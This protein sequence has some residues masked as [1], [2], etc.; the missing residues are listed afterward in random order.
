MLTK[1]QKNILDYIQGCHQ[2]NGY[3]PSH[4][5]IR[6]H[7]KLS[8]VSTV[9]HYIKILQ[10]K[11]YIKR[12][13][14][15]A[16]GVEIGEKDAVINIPFKG[17]IAAGQPIEAIEEYETITVPKNLVSTSGQ[18]FALG[19]KGDSM[20]DEGIFDGDTV[21]IRKQSNVENGETAI[22]LINGN[23]V[24]LKKIFKEKNRIRLQPANPNL[25]PLYVKSVVI[26]GKVISAFRNIEEQ[27]KRNSDGTKFQRP[28]F[29][30]DGIS[31]FRDDILK[32]ASIPNASI[33]LIVTSPPYNV[34]IHYNSHADNL[35]YE[36]YLEFTKKWI[37][38]CFDLAKSE[39]RFLLNI[40][41]DKNKGGQKSVGADITRIAK[42][43]GW[44][45]HS[46]IIW[47][48]GNISR[49]TAWGSFMSAS[50]PYV[51]AP[52]ELILVLYKDSWKKTGG[53]RKND[54]TKQEFMDWTN[55]IW[56]FPGQSKKGA[57]GH[58]APFPVELPR[59]CIKLFSFIDDTVLDP[60]LGS[61][62]TLIAACLHN[63]KGVGVDIDKDYCD[64][65][66]RRLQ[67][68]A[69]IKIN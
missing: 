46:T 66:I 30:K 11:G 61:G 53:S 50:A 7:F 54:I 38:R 65:A 43:I 29:E 32:I 58:P 21:I 26:Q 17:Y 23:E 40:P 60:F 47:N 1:K 34:D 12:A 42:D 16:R 24:T 25:K 69:K 15:A 3:S 48:E 45:Y 52:V 59:R 13:K 41:L 18:H 5:E 9:S 31:I 2:K 68:E 6:K 10:K 64:I 28:Y 55:G 19:V 49:R 33:D 51:I 44:K 4:E 62:S 37:K 63:R 36:D 20:I 27:E 14:N 39:G 8:S 67:Q 22:A 57:G 35:T 56:T